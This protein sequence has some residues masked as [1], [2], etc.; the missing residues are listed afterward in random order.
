MGR[1]SSRCR[2]RRVS[3]R[4]RARRRRSPERRSG[5][6]STRSRAAAPDAA[7][8]AAAPP[9][10]RIDDL[11]IDRAEFSVLTD[12]EPV[13]VAL[14]LQTRGL[15]LARDAPFPLEVALEAGR[16]SVALSGQLGLNPLVW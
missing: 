8:A 6:A 7:P 3:R 13:S 10:L 11:E 15:T 5:C 12:A 1:S 2:R 16:G 9:D 14:R 4:R